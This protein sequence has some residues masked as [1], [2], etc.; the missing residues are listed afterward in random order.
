[1]KRNQVVTIASI[2]GIFGIMMGI[3]LT[4]WVWLSTDADFGRIGALAKTEAGIVAKVKLLEHLRS[5]RYRDATSQL[6]SWLDYDLAGAGEFARDGAAIDPDTVSAME[7]ER[8]ARGASGY[9]PN[10]E[11]VSAAVQEA[12]QLVSGRQTATRTMQEDM[13]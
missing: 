9:V 10:D 2:A 3:L 6:E 4:S 1:M 13:R 8:Q 11:N 7:T 5:G 12:F